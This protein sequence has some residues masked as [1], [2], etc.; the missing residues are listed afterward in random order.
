MCCWWRLITGVS[1][2][3]EGSLCIECVRWSE[4]GA[5]C[6]PENNLVSSMIMGYR[7]VKQVVAP[8]IELN[9]G[10]K[11]IEDALQGRKEKCRRTE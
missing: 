2:S 9:T 7:S 4:W 3:T 8:R 10:Q 11:S 5:V 6:S 1:S